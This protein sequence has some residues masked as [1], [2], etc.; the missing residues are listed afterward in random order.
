[1]DGIPFP[2]EEKN[3]NINR[4]CD[5]RNKLHYSSPTANAWCTLSLESAAESRHAIQFDVDFEQVSCEWEERGQR[6]YAS[7]EYDK[8]ELDNAFIVE[9]DQAL[10]TRCH[11]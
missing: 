6:E 8:A 1:M 5:E 10:R 7:E 9:V 11:H 4:D 2:C 3:G